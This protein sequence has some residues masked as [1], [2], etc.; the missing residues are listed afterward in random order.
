MI[1]RSEV[2]YVAKLAKLE[3]SEEEMQS[4]TKQL[5]SI[6]G[7][8]HNLEKIDTNHLEPAAHILSQ[9]NIFR[10]DSVQKSSASELV[11]L[12]APQREGR[13]FQTP[14]I[15]PPRAERG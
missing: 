2:E 9:N 3:L 11:L 14:Q 13:Y 7:Y 6:L 1:Q 15:L 4:F 5:G 8:I 12:N 10:E